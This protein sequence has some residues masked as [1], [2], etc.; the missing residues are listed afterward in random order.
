MNECIHGFEEG[1]RS[2]TIIEM[3]Q[4]LNDIDERRQNVI[5][6]FKKEILQKLIG[7][8]SLNGTDSKQLSR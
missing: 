2:F 3:S 8:K 1:A 7:E 5:I 4:E 6:F